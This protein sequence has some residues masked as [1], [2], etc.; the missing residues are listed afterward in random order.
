MPHRTLQ[1]LVPLAALAGFAASAHAQP[2]PF[3]TRL[4]I[5]PGSVV[6]TTYD[7]VTNDLLTAGLGAAGI[8]SDLPPT[9]SPTPTAEDL[10]RL[11][12]YTNYRAL[13]DTTP[14]G[15]YGTFY[16]P[17]APISGAPIAGSAPSPNGLI[18]GQETI[19]Y[20]AGPGG[21][22]KITLMVQLP[23]SFDP[24]NACIVTAP[25][26][27]SRGIYGAI[28]TAGEW[29]LK[30]GCAVAYT[31]KGTGTGEDDLAQSLVT[32]LRGQLTPIADAGA[33]SQFTAAITPAQRAAFTAAFPNRFAVKH[34]H[35][36][37][38]PERDWGQDVLAS[39]RFAFA[40]IHARYPSVSRRNT[41]VIA[42]S[43]SNGGG[44]SVRA[45]EQDTEHLIDGLAVSEPN[46]N[47]IFLPTFTIN[48]AGR[49]PVARHSRPLI[50]YITIQNVY[51]GCA[52][53]AYTLAQ[54]PFDYAPSPG[55]CASLAAAGL[56][57]ST[58]LAAQAAEAQAI[59]NNYGILPEQ[60]L[61]QPVLWFAYVEQSISVTYANAYGRFSVLD[62]LC[63][64][65]FA[66]T[67]ATGAPTPLAPAAEAALFG[68]SNGIPPS[69]GLNLVNNAANL[70][71]RVSTPDQDLAGALCLR[72]LATGR[73]P[74]THAPL[75]FAQD[76][77]AL[78]IAEGVAEVLAF[79]D[80]HGT[81]ALI[82][83]GRSDDILPPNFVAR[84]YYGLNQS[85]EGRRSNLHYYEV[86][87]ANHLDNI[88]ALPGLDTTLIPL[89]RYFLEAL[90]VMYAHLKTG[91][92]LPPSQVVHT[93]PRGGTPGAAPVLTAANV[94]AISPTPGPAAITF[95]GRSLEIPE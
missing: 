24:A 56:L 35:S 90:D 55:R 79:G 16:G 6:T 54:A 89:Q 70:E 43:V 15:G 45:V 12:V 37:V 88:V 42:S 44:S 52:A 2:A 85:V 77:Q 20:A 9:I 75:T 86:T 38:N 8:A 63:G 50:D 66:A 22:P 14:G 74:A 17:S 31:D 18:P 33:L 13:I 53:A 84:A 26:S 76:I 62:N 93:T 32:T 72:A 59:L 46:V 3:T 30:H 65:S 27:G 7:G 4:A 5:V 11:A 69:A 57:Q 91:A 64:F 71:D 87:N 39:V 81:P 78:R 25:S 23:A 80:L 19:A 48:Q 82:V 73:N 47:P 34:A 67:A 60:N 49:A 29:G 40:I 94:P 36:Q 10:R 21:T 51:E 1:S 58:T 92:P 95:T 61:V 68:T 83:D 28:G 41:I